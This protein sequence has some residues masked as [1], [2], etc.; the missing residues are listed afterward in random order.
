MLST[1]FRVLVF[2]A[3]NVVQDKYTNGAKPDISQYAEST[4]SDT[5]IEKRALPGH[6]F[7]ATTRPIYNEGRRVYLSALQA[8]SLAM[9]ENTFANYQRRTI[10][11]VILKK[12]FVYH[13]CGP[14]WAAGLRLPQ[15]VGSEI[16]AQTI[17]SICN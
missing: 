11:P 5:T 3:M 17:R 1:G 7:S 6:G 4:V 15:D 16:S 2:L 10:S 13:A 8:L 12:S 9:T 14:Y